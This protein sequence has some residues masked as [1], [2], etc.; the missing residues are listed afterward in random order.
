MMKRAKIS[1]AAVYQ[2]VRRQAS[3]QERLRLF[4]ENIA[5]SPYGADQL[6]LE[7]IVHLRA[8]AAHVDLDHVGVA[9]E[10]HVPHLPRD[11]RPR[12]HLALAASEEGQE[13]ELLG[14]EVEA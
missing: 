14:G 5:H 8:Q 1:D 13:R 11:E 3:D 6:V 12:Q 2:V 7:G 10:V 9:V 4:V